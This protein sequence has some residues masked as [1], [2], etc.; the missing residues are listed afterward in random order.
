M[1]CAGSSIINKS[2]A[3]PDMYDE[4]PLS[5]LVLPPLNS[6]TAADAK[7]YYLTTVAEPLSQVGYYVF[8][9]EIVNEV[10]K[11]EGIYDSEELLNIDPTKFREYFNADAALFTNI[12]VWDTNYKVIA[13]SVT[14][15]IEFLLKSTHTGSILWSYNE[16]I[17]IDTSG[18]NS[19]I[20]V[21]LIQTAIK[22]ATQDYIPI[23]KQV[24]WRVLNTMPF[25]QYHLNHDLDQEVQS[26][27][28]NK[29]LK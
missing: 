18:D 26:V 29:T 5:I 22:T 6:T 7:D 28:K 3:F 1:N 8:P 20:L 19:N 16:A 17:T 2:E 4:K 14:V 21:S 15:H 25:G 12:L 13:G 23:A 10:M 27:N 11:N 9:I 24:N